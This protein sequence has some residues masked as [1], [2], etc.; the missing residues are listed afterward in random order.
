MARR[1]V[2]FPQG[3]PSLRLKYAAQAPHAWKFELRL[4]GLIVHHVLFPYNTWKRSKVRREENTVGQVDSRPKV[5]PIP[6]MTDRLSERSPEILSVL[7]FLFFN[8]MTIRGPTSWE[9]C[10]N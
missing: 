9:F 8:T 1:C 4:S 6:A 7:S 2:C 5:S 3:T 10:V